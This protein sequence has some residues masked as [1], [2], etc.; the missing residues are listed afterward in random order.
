MLPLQKDM[1][2]KIE[3][4]ILQENKAE[5]IFEKRIKKIKA[6]VKNKE[7]SKL[8]RELIASMFHNMYW[9][10]LSNNN[11]IKLAMEFSKRFML[12]NI[13][14]NDYFDIVNF[15]NGQDV[16][17]LLLSASAIRSIKSKVGRNS[18]FL[19]GLEYLNNENRKR[20]LSINPNY[21]NHLIKEFDKL[22]YD[23]NSLYSF[24]E[25]KELIVL[26]PKFD[27]IKNNYIYK[28]ESVISCMELVYGKDIYLLDFYKEKKELCDFIDNDKHLDIFSSNDREYFKNN[29]NKLTR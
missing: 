7:Y 23:Y 2:K 8:P 15:E 22:N 21:T 26:L 19:E 27:L 10:D 29:H 24:R 12:T 4:K 5:Q 18:N 9:K 3:D 13:N 6:K 17:E 16:I 25:I 11:K 20:F 28:M 1:F 14:L